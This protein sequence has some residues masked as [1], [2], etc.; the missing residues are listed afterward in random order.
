MKISRY[1]QV[2][3]RIKPV[4]YFRVT[5]DLTLIGAEH[6]QLLLRLT[7]MKCQLLSMPGICHL[8][9]IRSSAPLWWLNQYQEKLHSILH[10]K[11]SGCL[12]W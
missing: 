5:K 10:Y 7:G 8:V 3:V 6:L 9:K 4:N 12:Q 1:G 2:H 11:K